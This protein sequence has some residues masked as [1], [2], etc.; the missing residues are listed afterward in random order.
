MRTAH[1][2]IDR[3]GHHQCIRHHC[4]R[5][6]APIRVSWHMFAT[7]GTDLLKSCHGLAWR[8]RAFRQKILNVYSR[9]VP[10]AEALHRICSARGK[11]PYSISLETSFWM[12]CIYIYIYID[13]SSIFLFCFGYGSCLPL[14]YH[15]QLHQTYIVASIVTWEHRYEPRPLQLRLKLTSDC[16]KIERLQWLH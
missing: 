9:V 14:R 12:E 13:A 8:R 5:H 1:P 11:Y 7:W 15:L 4:L 3:H 16:H 6:W 2:W 10:D